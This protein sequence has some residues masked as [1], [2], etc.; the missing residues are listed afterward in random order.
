M[1]NVKYPSIDYYDDI[2]TRNAWEEAEEQNKD[3]NIFLKGVHRQSRDNART[4]LQW[5]TSKFAGFAGDETSG[6]K[7]VIDATEANPG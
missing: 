2:E 7:R 4:P 1:T 5:D 6:I 3:M